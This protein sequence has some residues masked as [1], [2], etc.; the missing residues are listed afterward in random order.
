MAQSGGFNTLL[1]QAL[2]DGLI[3]IGERESEVSGLFLKD[4]GL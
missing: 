3:S 2:I 4:M 1:T